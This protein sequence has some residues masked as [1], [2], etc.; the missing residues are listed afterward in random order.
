MLNDAVST[1]VELLEQRMN[2]LGVELLTESRGAGEVREEHR[3]LPPFADR[4]HLRCGRRRHAFSLIGRL[5]GGG[6]QGG[7]SVEQFATVA[8]QADAEFFEIPGGELR[9]YVRLYGVIAKRC[10]STSIAWG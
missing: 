5:G 2:L 7:D 3:H 6:A 1:V 4:I 8:D 10:C 9:Q